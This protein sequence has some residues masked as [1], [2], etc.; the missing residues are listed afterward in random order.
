MPSQQKPIDGSN[1]NPRQGRSF[2]PSSETDTKMQT[3]QRPVNRYELQEKLYKKQR[4]G[5]TLKE[6]KQEL[7][8]YE[9]E[10]KHQSVEYN[11]E[12]DTISVNGKVLTDDEVIQRHNQMELEEEKQIDWYKEEE[13]KR[14]KEQEANLYREEFK[15]NTKV[16]TKTYSNVQKYITTATRDFTSPLSR[17]LC[18]IYSSLFRNAMSQP[19]DILSFTYKRACKIRETSEISF[20]EL[21]DLFVGNIYTTMN[22]LTIPDYL[23][24]YAMEVYNYI[25]WTS[26]HYL[27]S[28]F[29]FKRNSDIIPQEFYD[30]NTFINKI[31]FPKNESV[32]G[33]KLCIPKRRYDSDNLVLFFY[34]LVEGIDLF[35]KNLLNK[36]TYELEK[37]DE[38]EIIEKLW[39]LCSPWRTA[40]DI[41]VIP[42]FEIMISYFITQL[43][44]ISRYQYKSKWPET[45]NQGEKNN[46][47]RMRVIFWETIHWMGITTGVLSADYAPQLI[48][49]DKQMEEV[50]NNTN[51]E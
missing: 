49:D 21:S 2:R 30:N 46:F 9:K 48:E 24:E 26:V 1:K 15:N 43:I 37:I 44:M 32:Q 40:P 17:G 45:V 42:H 16:T 6:K 38:N 50:N 3:K 25:Y 4:T 36:E 13:Y 7:Q 19:Y 47:K 29:G 20:L 11:R 51:N 35:V 22:V 10:K 5:K 14:D 8:N 18:V 34:K 27:A 23:S 28:Y 31:T 41:T 39:E 12:N 33:E